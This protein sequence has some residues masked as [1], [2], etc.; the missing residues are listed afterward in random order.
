MRLEVITVPEEIRKGFGFGTLVACQ[1]VVDSLSLSYDNVRLTV[2]G[3]LADLYCV[4][5]RRPD[6]VVL[7]V[8]HLPL[9]DGT[10]F[11][12]SRFFD[13]EG[14]V[15]TGSNENAMEYDINKESAKK[16]VKFFGVKTADYLIAIP[17]EYSEPVGLPIPYPLFLKP[18]SG[19][20]S[21]GIDS[22][23]LVRNFPEFEKKLASLYQR[24][25]SPVLVEKYLSGREFTVALIEK[26]DALLVAV[27]EIIA[28]EECGIRILSEK[29]KTQDN[30]FL[31]EVVDARLL[32]K[33]SN[34]ARKAFNA[35]GARDFARIDIKMDENE[36]CCFMEANL[37]PGLNKG[38]SYF[39]EALSISL[40]LSYD[41]VI[42]LIVK[43]AIS[44]LIVPSTLL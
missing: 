38:S 16:Q 27:I 10:K 22:D 29:V 13:K 2:C 5:A 19:A 14:I 32:V 23:S 26:E 12:L 3:S 44:R 1:S 42:G 7:G 6:L 25:S 36:E 4:V 20:D 39:P 30:E 8:K 41:D 37:T 21:L 40:G 9:E 35:L 24:G 34:L 15:Y 18:I 17:R 28:P 31:K 43:N 11:W 33:I